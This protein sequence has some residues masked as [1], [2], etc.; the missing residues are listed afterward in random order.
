M[1]DAIA[2]HLN[3]GCNMTWGKAGMKIEIAQ[4]LLS[5]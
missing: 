3:L 4:K 5:S 1:M 2:K